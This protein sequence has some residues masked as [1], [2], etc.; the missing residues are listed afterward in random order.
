VGKAACHFSTIEQNIDH[1]NPQTLHF[2]SPRLLF[3]A[4]A[5][6]G[7]S[8]DAPPPEAPAAPTPVVTASHCGEQGFFKA[9][10][11]GALTAT[12]DWPTAALRCESM[13]RPDDRGVRL[14]F[15]GEVRGERLAVII[16]MPELDAGAT[17]P[18]FD[19]IITVTVEG[20]G[21][22]FSTPNLGAC[23][24][25]VSTNDAQADGRYVVAGALTCVG[26]LGEFNGDAFVEVSDLQF[27]GI[28]DWEA[29]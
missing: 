1:G 27:R 14:R 24:T 26:P 11:S 15:S 25:A 18:E 21:R 2:D 12:V 29:T 6:A 28:A 22:F 20:S 19:T 8:E 4:L 3:V 5:L 13:R 16:A 9:R 7:C 10:L 23:W 17:G